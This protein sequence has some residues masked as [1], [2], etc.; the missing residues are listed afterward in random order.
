MSWWLIGALAVGAYAF[1]ALGFVGLGRV[2]L[3]GPLAHVVAYLPAALFTGI[4]MGEAT[5]DGSTTVVVTRLAGIAVGAVAA[6]RRA[7]L[8]LVIVLSAGSAALLRAIV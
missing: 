1:K 7:P 6:W 8:L 2:E 4:I 3:R 5:G